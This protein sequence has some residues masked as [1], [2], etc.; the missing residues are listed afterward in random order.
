MS[1]EYY[2]LREAQ[3]LADNAGALVGEANC[4]DALLERMLL[5]AGAGAAREAL[6]EDLLRKGRY[7]REISG[8]WILMADGIDRKDM[9]KIRGAAAGLRSVTL[10]HL[11]S[12]LTLNQRLKEE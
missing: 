12:P 2:D 7:Y 10:K 4:D 5:E 8:L 1:P 3:R 6:R 9:A 11:M